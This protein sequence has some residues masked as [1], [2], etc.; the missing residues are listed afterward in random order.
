MHIRSFL[1]TL[2]V[3]LSAHS[4]RAQWQWHNPLLQPEPVVTGRAWHDQLADGYARLPETARSM[5]RPQVWGLSR[6]SAGLGVDF[7]TNAADITVRY[8]VDG[9][10][11]MPHMP[12]TGVSGVDLYAY[13][14]E[15]RERWCAARYTFGDTITYRYRDLAYADARPEFGYNYHLSLPLY[16][17]V[18]W[19]EIGVPEGAAFAFTPV[20]T[21]RPI[22]V[23]GTSIAQGACASRP[24]MAWTNILSRETG[25]DIV[26]LGFSGNALVEA[27]VFDLM[28]QIDALMYVVD[29]MPNMCDTQLRDSIYDRTLAGVRCLRSRSNA[30]ILLVEHAG[31]TDDLTR[32]EARSQRSEGNANLRRA[33][34]RLVADGVAGVYYLSHDDIALGLDDMVEGVHPSD[35]G[36]RHIADAYLAAVRSI[37]GEDSERRCVFRP[38]PQQR[39]PYDW[40]TRHRN[41]LKVNAAEPPQVV[42]IGNS[43]THYWAGLPTGRLVR[44]TDSWESLWA[45]QVAHNLGFGW[46]RIENALWRIN[47]GELD[48]YDAEKVLLLLGTNNIAFNTDEEIADG[49]LE[50]VRSVRAH[51]PRAA[52]YVCSVLP[53]I[54]R[55]DRVAPLNAVIKSALERSGA[56]A[57][58]LDL[59]PM[60]YDAEGNYRNEL[61]SDGLHPNAEGYRQLADRIRLLLDAEAKAAR[62]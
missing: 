31:H 61:F 42:L 32:P 18:T 34:D 14:K 25:H 27:P 29:C 53:R 1:L 43:I 7:H 45:G 44:G 17:R 16:N 2:F 47:H 57:R 49:I 9:N 33:Y 12:A 50:V 24:G 5:V 52:I 4:A 28:S 41:V 60:A 22:V 8:T 10:L 13:D 21:E 11:A 30:P 62:R 51:Q 55:G 46:D 38:I 58:Y 56:P 3:L 20:S 26:N 35:L 59:T 36:M 48:G 40:Q 37:L 23:Y 15:G 39:D 54:D 19:L 6:Q